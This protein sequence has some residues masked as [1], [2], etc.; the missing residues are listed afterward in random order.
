MHCLAFTQRP[1]QCQ[2]DLWCRV[3]FPQCLQYIFCRRR[4]HQLHSRPIPFGLPRAFATAA[5]SASNTLMAMPD[6][7]GLQN[8]PDFAG[9][10]IKQGIR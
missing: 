8:L 1:V 6:H 5:R 9:S 3:S 2:A 7:S 4:H 10:I